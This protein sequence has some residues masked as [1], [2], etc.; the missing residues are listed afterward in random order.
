MA[1][2]PFIIGYGG[3][4]AAGLSSTNQS[5]LNMVAA[6]LSEARQQSLVS[7][8]RG[9]RNQEESAAPSSMSGEDLRAALAEQQEHCFIR[10]IPSHLFDT[11]TASYYRLDGKKEPFPV[12]FAATLP[13]GFAL[14]DLYNSRYHPRG[15]QLAVFAANDAMGLAGLDTETIHQVIEPHRCA[16]YAG[17]AL[18]QL[19]QDSMEGM[20]TAAL[21]E[22]KTVTKQLP[23]S[24]PQMAADF[25]NA[26]VLKNLGQTGNQCGAC[27]TFL[28]NLSHAVEQLK[29]GKIELALVGASEAPIM[30]QVIA[31]FH[32]MGALASDQKIGSLR[33]RQASVPFGD[34]HGFVMAEAAQFVILAS[35]EAA[36]HL[37]AAIYGM[38]SDVFISAD[39]GKHSI[40]APGP[41]N[42]VTVGR[43]AAALER[44][45]GADTL[46]HKSYVQAHGTSTPQN[47]VTESQ[48]FSSVATAFGIPEWNIVAIKSYIGHSQAAA[49]G[50][51][52]INSLSFW[53]YGVLPGIS[54]L[55]QPATD[56]AT[57]HLRF[58]LAHKEVGVE[59]MDAALV[60]AKGFGGNNATAIISSPRLARELFTK[61]LGKKQLQANHRAMERTDKRRQDYLASANRGKFRIRYDFDNATTRAE[62]IQ[63][64]RSGVRVKDYPEIP[65]DR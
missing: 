28:Y 23:F 30:P 5:Y 21:R 17:S 8:L 1:R 31:A 52:L 4:N 2:I 19:D 60:N 46:R 3:I 45:H 10:P 26:Y 35:A 64:S 25:V 7:S 39:G 58:N 11:T 33:P 63:L 37:G 27:A 54:T 40:S 38:V 65:F 41:G 57:E 24:Y 14:S 48:I 59:G 61:Q 44:L 15:L 6:E 18:G 56:V 9:I 55:R 42:Y 20:L 50:D 53:Q 22:K 51:Q 13:D 29:C 62:D 49:G 36:Y 12:S 43:A 34:N 16:V 47:R 32:N